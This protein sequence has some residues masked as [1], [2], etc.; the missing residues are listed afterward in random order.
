MTAEPGA[1]G[2]PAHRDEALHRA[3]T[4]TWPD[5]SGGE[6]LQAL[7]C[8]L[9]PAGPGRTC[10]HRMA[11]AALKVHEGIRVPRRQVLEVCSG[12]TTLQPTR[13][14]RSAPC[15]AASSTNT[16]PCTSGAF[17]VS[18]RPSCLAHLLTL[19][20]WPCLRASRRCC[21]TSFREYKTA[22]TLS[23]ITV[24]M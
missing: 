16:R 1:A 12:S 3:G 21:S 13:R 7:D 14:G 9:G 19:I 15:G 18:G 4:S 8:T 20:L 23:H 5:L 17:I 11:A 10:G 22:Y 24:V 6:L 2:G